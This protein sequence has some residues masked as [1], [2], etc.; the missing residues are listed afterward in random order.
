MY[1]LPGKGFLRAGH[2][3]PGAMQGQ[4]LQDKPG[5]EHEVTYF[6][7]VQGGTKETPKMIEYTCITVVELVL[8]AYLTKSIY[9]FSA[10]Q[11]KS[12]YGFSKQL[13]RWLEILDKKENILAKITMK[14]SI[15]GHAI[16][17]T[18]TYY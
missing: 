14:S 8:A 13:A 10:I 6:T 5:P 9:K 17:E 15:E 2:R 1:L 16:S 4:G 18:K 12:Q 11:W 3:E 7:S